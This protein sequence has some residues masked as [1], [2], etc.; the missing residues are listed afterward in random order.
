MSVQIGISETFPK[1]TQLVQRGKAINPLS[2]PKGQKFECELCGKPAYIQCKN[3]RLTYYCD[4][5][6]ETID[7]RGIHEK[8]C[9]L[10]IPLRTPLGDFG[11]EEERAYRE[12]QTRIRQMNLLE[13]T[14][15]EA[16]KKLF[17]SQF[18]L[19]IPAALQA[20][21]FSMDVYGQDSIELVP[22]YLLLGEASIGLKQFS[23]AEDYLSLAKWAVLKADSAC[24]P[25]IRAQL[26]RNLGLMFSSQGNYDA[27]LLQ[28]AND[29][30]FSSIAKSPD[31]ITTSGGYFQLGNVFQKLGRLED[32][33]ATFDKVISI[34][35]LFLKEKT[36]FLNEA[37]QAEAVQILTTIHSFRSVHMN[38]SVTSAAEV[39]Y[40]LAQLYNTCNKFD[41]AKA[42]AER[43]LETY[44][45]ALGRDH[46][47][48]VE[49]K[50]FY[51]GI[52]VDDKD[53]SPSSR[54][55]SANSKSRKHSINGMMRRTS[56]VN[57]ASP[58][59]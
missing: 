47:M 31:H 24:H 41:K 51:K 10:I 50:I 27:A 53:S 19:A 2:N 13:I 21:R 54:I 36:K 44:E 58:S 30:F 14:K 9:Q 5:D 56:S 22:S 11:S 38:S 32:A 3:C 25:S 52:V 7:F 55:Q 37:Q 45:S 15:I 46:S 33:T 29:I 23:Q 35:K 26:H 57:S 40:V 48:T 4:K 28:L 42:C 6:H 34:W 12:K 43:A 59:H 1:T 8:I 49:V 18:D 39:M 20:L 16:H 17:E